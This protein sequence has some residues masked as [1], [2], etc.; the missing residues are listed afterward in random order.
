MIS[1]KEKQVQHFF[2]KTKIF[3]GEGMYLL[4]IFSADFQMGSIP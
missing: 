4:F 3:D 1:H 2:S